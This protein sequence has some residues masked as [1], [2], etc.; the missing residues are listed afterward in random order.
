MGPPIGPVFATHYEFR[1]VSGAPHGGASDAV[2]AGWVRESVP[3]GMLTYAALLARLDSFWPAFFAVDR[4]RRPMATVSFMAE[5]LADPATLDPT[6]PMFYRAR[7]VAQAGGYCVE[8]RELWRGS[9]P[10]AFNQQSFA[11]LA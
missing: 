4:V 8:L 5:F 1:L 7:A 6:V 9:E 11:L 10:V 3:L 2:V